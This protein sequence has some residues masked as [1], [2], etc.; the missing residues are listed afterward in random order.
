M[1]GRLGERDPLSFRAVCKAECVPARGMH[2]RCL[3]RTTKPRLALPE[4][5]HLGHS[6]DR[7]EEESPKVYTNN[8]FMPTARFFLHIYDMYWPVEE[9]GN[10]L[11]M[12][13][14]LTRATGD[15]GYAERHWETLT[16]WAE[17]LREHGTDTGG[18]NDA[19]ALVR[20]TAPRHANLSLKAVLAVAAYAQ[21]AELLGKQDAAESY[22]QAAGEMAAEW[23]EL[24]GAGDHTRLAF[25][26]PD[27]SWGMKYNLVWDDLLGLRLFPE[28]MKR[29]EAAFYAKKAE[30]YGVPLESGTHLARTEWTLWAA[31]L[32]GDAETAARLTEPLYRYMDEAESRVP[33]PDTYD[34][35]SAKWAKQANRPAVG[36][37]F[38]RLAGV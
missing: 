27:E 9:A 33:M 32:A 26:Q 22:R 8:R 5:G 14:A 11:L 1:T 34:A 30:A 28:E 16:A 29:Q 37:C 25:G 23:T 6:D 24:A 15:A 10:A 20:K 3:F 18:Q 12:T 2:A 17:Y 13:A 19:D 4:A 35:G 36:G 31:M 21:L 38:I 7:R